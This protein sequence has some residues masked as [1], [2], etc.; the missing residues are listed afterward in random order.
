MLTAL[1]R[2]IRPPAG[3]RQYVRMAWR[4]FLFGLS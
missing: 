4:L 3:K 1:S 2:A